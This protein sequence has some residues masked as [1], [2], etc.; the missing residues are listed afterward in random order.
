MAGIAPQRAQTNNE[1]DD[2]R[3]VEL[4]RNRAA[5]KKEFAQ[6]RKENYRLKEMIQDQENA[7]VGAQQQLD[8]LEALLAEPLQA[9]NAAVFFQLRGIWDL[10]LK[11][12]S[13]L[14]EELVANQRERE[15]RLR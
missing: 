12:L 5:L 8:Q 13:R 2:A 1:G 4:F 14:A 15:M 10:C 3:L 9:S 7:K 11:R 6:L